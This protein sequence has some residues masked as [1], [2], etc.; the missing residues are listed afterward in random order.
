MIIEEKETLNRLKEFSE[1]D[2]EEF[3]KKVQSRKKGGQP[4]GEFKAKFKPGG[5][6]EYQDLYFK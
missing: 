4:A 3:L 2:K 1:K 6:Q 5:P